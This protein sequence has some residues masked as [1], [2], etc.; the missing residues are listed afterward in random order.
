[1]LVSGRARGTQSVRV[2]LETPAGEAND[3]WA[4]TVFFEGEDR[5]ANCIINVQVAF[6]LEGLYWFQVWLADGFLTKLPYRLIYDRAPQM[7]R[8]Q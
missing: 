2:I 3:V 7:F 4:G 5:G 6:P 8:L 1:M